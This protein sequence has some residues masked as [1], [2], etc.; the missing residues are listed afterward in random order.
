MGRHSIKQKSS[1]EQDNI[2]ARKSHMNYG[3]YTELK[4]R[5]LLQSIEEQRKLAHKYGDT[6]YMS[7]RDR[8]KEKK[9]NPLK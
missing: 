3:Y 7:V 4:R 5:E 1:L 6:K 2:N 8:L 9:T